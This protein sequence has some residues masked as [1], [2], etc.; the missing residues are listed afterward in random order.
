MSDSKNNSEL[1]AA[2]EGLTAELSKL[3]AA[4]GKLSAETKVLPAEAAALAPSS[5]AVATIQSTPDP[6][7]S[8]QDIYGV[9]AA[10]FM[11]VSDVDDEAGFESFLLLVHSDRTEAPRSI[12]SLREF[13]WKSLKQKYQS[14]LSDAGD[15]TS[16]E[17]VR[18]E[19]ESIDVKTKSAKI[20]LKSEARSPVPVIFKRDAT[21]AD[22]WRIT[23]CSL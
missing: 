12:P 7:L 3:R 23:D 14:Y 2:I 16:F 11:A 21:K 22:A 8:Y 18:R 4:V 19:P 5:Q 9:L 6:E 20:F 10:T 13:T 1:I 15:A 17:V